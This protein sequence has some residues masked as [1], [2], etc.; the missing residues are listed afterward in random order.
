MTISVHIDQVMVEGA[1]LT[2][3]EREQLAV[4]LE[5]ELTRLL[6]QRAAGRPAPPPIAS[7]PAGDARAGV[8]LG[9]RIAGELLAALPASTFGPPVPASP[10]A[11]R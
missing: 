9:R 6:R 10:G 8:T 1:A 7:Q 2:R 4:T 3:R 5:Q 11:G